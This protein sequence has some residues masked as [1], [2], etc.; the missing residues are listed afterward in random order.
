M[1]GAT[2]RSPRTSRNGDSRAGREPEK[3]RSHAS[4]PMAVTSDN[5]RAGSR[6]PMALARP[7][8]SGMAS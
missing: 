6:N 3:S 5:L 4:D 7:D 2:W 1:A 8:S